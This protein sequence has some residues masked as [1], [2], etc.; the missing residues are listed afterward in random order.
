MS[1]L[2][3]QVVDIADEIAYDDHDLEDGIISGAI[4]NYIRAF[5]I[6]LCSF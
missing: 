6:K 4:N 5:F 1:F 2:E 3:I